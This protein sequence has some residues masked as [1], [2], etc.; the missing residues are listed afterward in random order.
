MTKREIVV[1]VILAG[2]G[3]ALWIGIANAAGVR[4]AWDSYLFF[5]IGLP[6]ML[7]ATAVAG[8][9]EPNRT[10]LWGVAVVALQPV[11]LLVESGVGPLIGVGIF[12]FGF[13]REQ[14]CSVRTR[15]HR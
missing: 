9:T 8:Y 11:A 14:V 3:L 4:E 5:M 15:G 7:V 6:A 1:F 13:L 2:V 12:F 10:W